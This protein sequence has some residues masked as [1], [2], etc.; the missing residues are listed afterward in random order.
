MRIN[1]SEEEFP[2]Q[3]ELWQANCSRS[4]KGKRGQAELRI[5]RDALLAL[6]EKRLIE[7]LLYDD[8]GGVCAI[9]AYAKHKGLDI[10]KED[11]EDHTDQ[12][13]IDAGMPEMLAW[14]VVEMN[15]EEFSGYDFDTRKGT[16]FENRR[17]TPERRFQMMLNWVESQLTPA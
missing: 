2:G 7:G 6:P 8:E 10:Q 5:L 15:D 4:I 9:G 17:I 14:K 16:L 1:Y 11:P 13:G 12:V 3:F